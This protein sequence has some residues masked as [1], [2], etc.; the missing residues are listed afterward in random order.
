M[1]VFN[2]FFDHVELFLNESGICVAILQPVNDDV[3]CEGVG[4]YFCLLHFIHEVDHQLVVFLSDG[5]ADEHIIGHSVGYQ[6]LLPHLIQIQESFLEVLLIAAFFDDEIEGDLIG[7][8][9]LLDHEVE[10]V[11]HFLKFFD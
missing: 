3:V 7:L 2:D 9:F 1:V 4:V 8:D 11:V 10:E 5:F 6:G